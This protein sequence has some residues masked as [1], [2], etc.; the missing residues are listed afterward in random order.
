MYPPKRFDR[1]DI[2]HTSWDGSHFVVIYIPHYVGNADGRIVQLLFFEKLSMIHL[3]PFLLFNKY[4][5]SNFI[6]K[7]KLKAKAC[8][9]IF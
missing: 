5:Q 6:F 3:L 1:D 7:Q 2:K 4:K 9:V 8:F